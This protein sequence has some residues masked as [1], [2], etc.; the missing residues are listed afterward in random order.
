MFLHILLQAA[1]GMLKMHEESLLSADNSASIFNL[2]ST[3]PSKV[4]DVEALLE[5]M[6]EVGASVTD[7]IIEDN[8][9]R[10]VRI[11]TY[12]VERFHSG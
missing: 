9:R 2:L 8:R 7:V 4:D 11:C 6:G 5:A 1:L 10:Q 12:C 3:L